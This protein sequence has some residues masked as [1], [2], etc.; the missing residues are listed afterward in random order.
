MNDMKTSGWASFEEFYPFYLR[1]HS[2]RM[3]KIMHFTGTLF[4]VA[5]LVN[6]VA[7]GSLYQLWFLPVF[8]YG[9]AWIGHFVFEKNRPATFKA[10]FYSLRGDFTMFWHLL[11]GR[12]AFETNAPLKSKHAA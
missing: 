5:I 2:N 7:T 1:E 6:A 9:F 4:V 12:L 3:C 11:T 10:P 8:G